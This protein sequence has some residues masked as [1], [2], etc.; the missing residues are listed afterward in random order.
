MTFLGRGV[1]RV[2]GT[3]GEDFVCAAGSQRGDVH[4]PTAI[5]SAHQLRDLVL[6]EDLEEAHKFDNTH[7][8]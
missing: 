5:A 4:S 1:L 2:Q 8:G 6:R 7:V 3:E